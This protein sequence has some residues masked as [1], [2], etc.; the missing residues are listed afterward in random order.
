VESWRKTVTFL[1]VSP[2]SY[3]NRPPESSAWS[4]Q[5][6]SLSQIRGTHSFRRDHSVPGGHDDYGEVDDI[7]GVN[8]GNRIN[9]RRVTC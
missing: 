4:V 6:G 7:N 2:G 9:I 3:W 1:L 8:D 5:R